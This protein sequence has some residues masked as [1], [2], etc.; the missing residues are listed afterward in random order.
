MD[1]TRR[2]LVLVLL[3]LALAGIIGYMYVYTDL[4]QGAVGEGTNQAE[5]ST[6]WGES[7]EIS[8]D[9]LTKTSSASM[10]SASYQETDTESAWTVNTTYKSQE[11]VTLAYD[12]DV[13]YTQVSNIEATVKIKAIDRSDASYYE[14]TIAN[15]KSLGGASPIEDSGDTGRTIQGHIISDI[16]ASTSGALIQYEIYCQVSA[17]GTVSGETLT[18]TIP[19]TQFT[20]LY[21][22]YELQQSI[23]EVD[24]SITVTSWID[25]RL[26]LPGE[27]VL[28]FCALCSVLS[29]YVFWRRY[30]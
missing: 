21:Y 30:Y 23:I 25:D 20:S 26:G 8:L 10:F 2:T 24:P 11:M 18:A 16:V 27:T 29:A 19:Y 9:S 17:T 14:Y 28:N 5:A 3:L 22:D 6:P 13:T 7:L 12:L 1:S 4:I 15:A